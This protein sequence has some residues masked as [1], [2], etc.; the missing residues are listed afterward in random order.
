MSDL[1]NIDEI[2]RRRTFAI[3]SH[4]D[5]GKTTITEKMLFLGKVVYNPG[6]IKAK[7]SNRYAKSDWME[8]ERR[9]GISITSS[10]IQFT[11]KKC[12]INLLDTPG[13][14]DFSEDTYRTLSA[15]DFCLMVIDAAKGV[16]ER[17]KKLIEITRLRKTPIITFINKLDRH[18][19]DC[20][21]VLD[22]IEKNLN[23]NCI[24]INWPIGS[25]TNFYGIYDLKKKSCFRYFKKDLLNRQ[26]GDYLG[27]KLKSHL[28]YLESIYGKNYRKEISEELNLVENVYPK[29]TK[30]NF[31]NSISTPVLFGTALGNFGIKNILDYIVR[32]A[33]YPQSRKTNVRIIQPAEPF[34][35]GFIF[36]I[37]ANMNLR[38]RDRIAFMRIVSGTFFQGMKLKHV[39]TG[40]TILVSNAVFFIAGERKSVKKACSGDII[41]LYNHGTINIGD[42]FTEGETFNF[43]E[44]PRFVPEIFKIVV[45]R[46]PLRKKQLLKGLIQLSEE[47]SIQV[48][49]KINSNI[50]FL[51]AIGNL[52][53]DVVLERLKIEY[54]VEIMYNDTNIALIRWISPLNK[55]VIDLENFK[56]KYREF[57]AVDIRNNLAY[58]ATSKANL[59]I[60]YSFY[61]D[62]V[63]FSKTIN[64]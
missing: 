16:E 4:P 37:Q 47:G 59:D 13:H 36:K 43:I 52:Q 30:K 38:H 42:T 60:V 3:I 39:R 54:K 5:A 6:T 1:N 50:L 21:S 12:L 18:S 55:K 15:V 31:L 7:G 44:F 35:T 40:K 24:P 19:K 26:L 62:K 64:Y 33:P 14:E 9:R 57:L 20:V 17:T 32:K 63:I 27:S 25:G 8:I 11:Y 41:G 58:L 45:L 48:F 22:E 23:I 46:N 29:F 34:F 49:K 28:F 56:R 61:K 51:G 53:F 10:A 2:K